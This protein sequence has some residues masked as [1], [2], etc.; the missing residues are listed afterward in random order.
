MRH[1]P[2]KTNQTNLGAS[3]QKA[4]KVPS[5]AK[6]SKS[7]KP[8]PSVKNAPGRKAK[9]RTHG[10]QNPKSSA[11]RKAK[12]LPPGSA[13]PPDDATQPVTHSAE[14]IRARAYLN[15]QKRGSEDGDHTDDWLRAEAELAAERRIVR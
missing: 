9:P 12:P 2:M 13:A 4:A 5:K 10:V 8:S 11:A 3:R 1:F 6:A 7:L 15:Y 14:A